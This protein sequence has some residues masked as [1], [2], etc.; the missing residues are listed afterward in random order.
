MPVEMTSWSRDSIMT[1]VRANH[2]LA[3]APAARGHR[4]TCGVRTDPTR[5]QIRSTLN[6]Q[7][8]TFYIKRRNWNYHYYSI[9]TSNT[10]GFSFYIQCIFSELTPGYPKFN[11]DTERRSYA[12]DCVLVHT[13]IYML[14][15]SAK[16]R[17]FF[18]YYTNSDVM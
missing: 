17:T 4:C 16:Y 5:T 13:A 10:F 2:D 11:A 15:F 3:R 18:Y 8:T 12:L 1:T 6:D 7:P 9:I 14:K